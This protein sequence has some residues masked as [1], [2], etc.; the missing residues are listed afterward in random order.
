MNLHRSLKDCVLHS[1]MV[2]WWI[3][4]LG[5]CW[6]LDYVQSLRW[7]WML[8]LQ[9]WFSGSPFVSW[10]KFARVFC[11]FLL[12]VV[13][14]FL[15]EFAFTPTPVHHCFPWKQRSLRW[16]V[17]FSICFM[18][19]TVCFS[20]SLYNGPFRALD[21]GSKSFVLLWWVIGAPN[22]G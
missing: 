15:S 20:T 10:G 19:S 7:K 6:S 9:I 12:P 17:L 18:T 8:H 3:I 21:T 13:H 14:K 1:Q 2:T 16:L 4:C 5:W 22:F 11:P